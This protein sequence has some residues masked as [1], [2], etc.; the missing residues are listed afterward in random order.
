MKQTIII[1]GNK[2]SS[3]ETFYDEVESKLT[4][5]LDWSIG[6]NLDAFNDVLRGGFGVYEY[7][8]P[9]LLIWENSN[10]S[11]EKLGW[12]ETIKYITAKLKTCHPAN[13]Q[14]V[15]D[16]LESAKQHK[17]QTLFELIVDIISSHKHIKLSLN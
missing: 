5:N 12:N 14:L 17:G 8:E 10:E 13:I 9:I 3:L 11:K 7:E 1:S 2:I 16:K 15:K 4:K 6:R